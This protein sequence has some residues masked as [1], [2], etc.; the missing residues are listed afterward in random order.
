M[1]IYWRRRDENSK[2]EATVT[3]PRTG[4]EAKEMR[5]YKVLHWGIISVRHLIFA[6]IGPFLTLSATTWSRVPSPSTLPS[7]RQERWGVRSWA[8][9]SGKRDIEELAE[10]ELGV[11]CAMEMLSWNCRNNARSDGKERGAE[12]GSNKPASILIAQ[13]ASEAPDYPR[14]CS[15]RAA[16]IRAGTI[17]GGPFEKR[18]T[19]ADIRR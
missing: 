4:R 17:Y 3:A 1:G 8:E 14:R 19:N 6:A 11:Q 15:H 16:T 13:H 12:V 5:L 9:L 18:G 2:R 10:D 7:G